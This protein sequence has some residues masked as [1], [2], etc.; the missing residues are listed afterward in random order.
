MNVKSLFLV[1]AGNTLVALAV[2]L[3]LLPG[4]MITGGATGLAIAANHYFALPL[5]LFLFIF[6]LIM[7]LLGAFILGRGFALTTLVSTFYYPFILQVLQNSGLCFELTSDRMLA[8]ICGGLLMG[9][10]LGIVIRTGASTGGM[11]VPPLVLKKKLG[12]PVS[13]S[14]YGFDLAILLLQAAFSDK[15]QIL[16]GILLVLIYSITLD[17]VLVIGTGQIKV[18]IIS[19]AYDE[20]NQ[21]ILKDLNRGSTLIQANTGYLRKN[22]PLVLTVMSN[23][24]LVRL[25]RMV[26][27]IDPEAFLIISQVKEVKGHGFSLTKEYRHRPSDQPLSHSENQ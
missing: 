7:F 22:Q 1:L 18:E 11:D 14:L 27:T 12:I 9:F 8:T 24:E 16:Y 4:G 15:E 23:R 3:F 10:A 6:N 17:K 5:S 13:L 2:V 19:Q 21:L 25:N 26:L 20:I